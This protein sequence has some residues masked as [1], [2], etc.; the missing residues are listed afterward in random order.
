MDRPYVHCW[1]ERHK[2]A[3][4]LLYNKSLYNKSEELRRSALLMLFVYC[5]I[6]DF[7]YPIGYYQSI[8]NFQLNHLISFIRVKFAC[9]RGHDNIIGI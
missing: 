8:L 1:I 7:Y 4:K 9:T 3:N 5:L 6:K 2:S